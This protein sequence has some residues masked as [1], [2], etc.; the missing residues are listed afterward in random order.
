MADIAPV[1][2]SRERRGGRMTPVIAKTQEIKF[3]ETYKEWLDRKG[4][5]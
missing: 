3:P 1:P 2:D 5:Y 4:L